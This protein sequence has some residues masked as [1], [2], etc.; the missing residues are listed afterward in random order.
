MT[1]EMNDNEELRLKTNNGTLVINV[2]NADTVYVTTYQ[3]NGNR[4]YVLDRN[5]QDAKLNEI[6]N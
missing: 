6:R 5:I 3:R 1:I 2:V 4:C